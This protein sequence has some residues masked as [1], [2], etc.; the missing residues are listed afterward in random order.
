MPPGLPDNTRPGR[1]NRVCDAI[2]HGYNDRDARA[3]DNSQSGMPWR[4]RRVV[5]KPGTNKKVPLSDLYRY[6]LNKAHDGVMF[7][8]RT[9]TLNTQYSSAVSCHE[10][11]VRST[12]GD[13]MTELKADDMQLLCAFILAFDSGCFSVKK[14]KG[15]QYVC[16]KRRVKIT[17]DLLNR[18]ETFY[19]MPVDELIYRFDL[20]NKK[21][22]KGFIE[23]RLLTSLKEEAGKWMG[24]D[25]LS[26]ASHN[27]DGLDAQSG[28]GLNHGSSSAPAI[29]EI[30]ES[31]LTRRNPESE[32]KYSH[33]MDET[34]NRLFM[35]Y[36]I[37]I[38]KDKTL[39]PD[40]FIKVKCM[41]KQ[42]YCEERCTETDIDE[43]D[44]SLSAATMPSISRDT[45]TTMVAPQKVSSMMKLD[46][47]Y[48]LYLKEKVDHKKN[49]RFQRL[50][51]SCDVFFQWIARNK[52][53]AIYNGVDMVIGAVVGVLLAHLFI[54]A[55]IYVLS[56]FITIIFW[57]AYDSLVT[58]AKKCYH[59]TKVASLEARINDLEKDVDAYEEFIKIQKIFLTELGDEYDGMEDPE[60]EEAR[61]LAERIAVLTE[62][63]DILQTQLEKLEEKIHSNKYKLLNSITFL[64]GNISVTDALVAE[65]REFDR[66]ARKVEILKTK[67]QRSLEDEIHYAKALAKLE[68]QQIRL[69]TAMLPVNKM[70][71][72][73]YEIYTREK[74]RI[75]KYLQE[76]LSS[77]SKLFG[78]PADGED[79][80]DYEEGLGKMF[81]DVI[82][83]RGEWEPQ[84]M[85]R[86]IWSFIY[87][88]RVME[89]L[90]TDYLREC[91]DDEIAMLGKLS[92][93]AREI[94]PEQYMMVRAKS[95]D[96]A[97]GALDQ[98][99]SQR[100]RDWEIDINL[101]RKI[102][103]KRDR[104]TPLSTSAE[105]ECI[106]PHEI[107]SDNVKD[108]REEI[109]P[110]QREGASVSEGGESRL[111]T[112]VENDSQN[113]EEYEF[114]VMEKCG[115][116]EYTRNI[117]LLL[118]NLVERVRASLDLEEA[119]GCQSQQINRSGVFRSLKTCWDYVTDYLVYYFRRIPYRLHESGVT[120]TLMSGERLNFRNMLK[121][122]FPS[123]MASGG[124]GLVLWFLFKC[125]GDWINNE[126]D[127][128]N[129]GKVR[130]R[131][132]L[133]DD[134]KSGRHLM[135][136]DRKPTDDMNKDKSG[137]SAPADKSV[138]NGNYFNAGI[139]SDNP[140]TCLPE[141]D[142][143]ALR[144]ELKRS[145]QELMP[146]LKAFGKVRVELD[147]LIRETRSRNVTAADKRK[148]VCLQ[149]RYILI[150][151]GIENK[152][153]F[154]ALEQ[155]NYEVIRHLH[156]VGRRV[157]L[158]QGVSA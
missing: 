63:F 7:S 23:H 158:C 57:F 93:E 30:Q 79:Q 40:K 122:A 39:T 78:G 133:I 61:V 18:L 36:D 126:N 150:A 142:W 5:V 24:A 117:N 58:Y 74:S 119:V 97:E 3:N 81:M 87:K 121:A 53:I 9:S 82:H 59:Q 44:I 134:Y 21:L 95:L 152:R 91:K 106:S 1:L 4:F 113:D 88:P 89:K 139:S 60:S 155:P 38:K 50:R 131:E 33:Q 46:D 45:Q 90:F 48:L 114:Y 31:L 120:M 11:S 132:N 32:K 99:Q 135:G 146:L 157:R 140:L 96:D 108:T 83:K 10:L 127:S 75:E 49:N 28:I 6:C 111:S 103:R 77:G 136:D 138:R 67:V 22:P 17:E 43:P 129:Q 65:R 84:T 86:K 151:S 148:A 112:G 100:I 154:K 68:K 27:R 104:K 42:L 143:R 110:I 92:A 70:V 98:A 41:L 19:A 25:S 137:S 85:A 2:L 124:L 72:L 125:F 29:C 55:P 47:G 52:R 80:K 13:T 102:Q 128:V 123:P 69:E 12:A 105:D 15:K 73:T 76:L 37:D 107:L 101:D 156:R 115:D 56:A 109:S 145:S 54:A 16:M 35:T 14:Y 147:K 26:L 62:H 144:R 64:A 66:I 153:V 8:E 141:D 51:K 130:M 94:K 116:K 20:D 71:T 34:I 149:L 118:A